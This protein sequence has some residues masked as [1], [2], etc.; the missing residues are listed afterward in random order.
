MADG[1]RHGVTLHWLADIPDW[2]ARLRALPER[3][4][5][6]AWDEVVALAN[7]PLDFVRTNQLDA[8][9]RRACGD[10][11]PPGIAT[12]PIRLAIIGSATL[13]HLHSGIRIGTAG[14]VRHAC[15]GSGISFNRTEIHYI[16][17]EVADPGM[18]VRTTYGLDNRPGHLD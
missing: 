14:P 2:R 12:R 7:A 17:S 16:L 18:V 11:P 6:A 10:A 1:D 3:E 13:A 8:M 15:T 5:A 4:P 9:L